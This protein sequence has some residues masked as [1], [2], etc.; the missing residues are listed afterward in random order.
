MADLTVWLSQETGMPVIDGVVCAVKMLEALIGAGLKTSK[1][2][3][4]AWPRRK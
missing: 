4:Y 3:A 2:G 1:I